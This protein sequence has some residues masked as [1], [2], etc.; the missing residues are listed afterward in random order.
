MAELSIG[1]EQE[2]VWACI[3]DLF[4]SDPNLAQ[5]V[6]DPEPPSSC[7]WAKASALSGRTLVWVTMVTPPLADASPLIAASTPFIAEQRACR[8]CGPA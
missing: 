7:Q 5:E 1:I 3:R 6:F 2:A 8:K 4:V